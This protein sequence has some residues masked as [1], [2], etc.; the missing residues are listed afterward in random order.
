MNEQ[1]LSLDIEDLL[2]ARNP[3]HMQVAR[4]ALVPGYYLRAARYLKDLDGVVL[5]ATGFP[6]TGTFETDGPVGAIILYQALASLGAKP[7][8][9]CGPP[10]SA[11]LEKDYELLQLTATTLEDAKAEAKDNLARLKPQAIIA[12]ERPGLAADGRYYNM[13]GVDIS[14]RCYFFDPYMDQAD[15]PTI[16]IGD[17][18]NECGMGKIGA[19]LA[20]LD[21]NASATSCDEL[22]VADVS[23]WGAYGLLA[24]LSIWARKD[25]LAGISPVEILNYLCIR[26][27][28]D[29][30]TGE[31]TLTEDGMDARVGTHIIH[32][33]RSLANAVGN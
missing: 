31:S 7:V 24:I 11:V 8:L 14:E 13:R 27:S 33:L 5:I 9:V 6:V 25:L 17:G 10:L 22:L 16:G 3:R 21:I 19:A 29:G 30:V 26:G 20:S 1:Q 2:V 15:C 28:V 4:D 23:N 12:I 18:G 32:E